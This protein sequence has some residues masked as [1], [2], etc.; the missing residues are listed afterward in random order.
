MKISVFFTLEEMQQ[1]STASRVGVRNEAPPVAVAALTNLCKFVLDPL[2]EKLGVAIHVES[3]YRSAAVNTLVGGE[4]HSQH[5]LG[6]AADIQVVGIAPSVVQQVIRSMKLPIDQ[7]I[8]EFDEWVHV[9]RKFG[10]AQR[11]Q[12]LKSS[13]VNGVRTY[14][15]A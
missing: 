12:Y 4:E 9:S 2:R 10:E 3:G 15:N 6:E 8:N 13:M 14:T 11:G 5:L 1:S 7:C